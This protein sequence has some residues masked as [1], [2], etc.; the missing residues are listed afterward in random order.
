MSQI[1][2]SVNGE[3]THSNVTECDHSVKFRKTPVKSN[4]QGNGRRIG[5]DM[6]TKL[7][8]SSRLHK[9]NADNVHRQSPVMERS[10]H[11]PKILSLRERKC[12]SDD[13]TSKVIGTPSTSKRTGTRFR[14]TNYASSE[15]K[16]LRKE[17][18]QSFPSDSQEDLS[19]LP[20]DSESSFPP[21]QDSKA[22]TKSENDKETESVQSSD[23]KKRMFHRV[24]L[25]THS[26]TVPSIDENGEMKSKIDNHTT[27]TPKSSSKQNKFDPKLRRSKVVEITRVEI[28]ASSS[29]SGKEKL[30]VIDSGYGNGSSE[31][32]ETVEDGIG[33][34]KL[35]EK[36]EYEVKA[37]S[38]SPNERFLKFDIEIGRGSFKTVFKGLDTET[39][40]AVAWCE[41]QDYLNDKV[42]G[43]LVKD[44]KWNKSER[45]RFKEEAEMLKGLQHPNIVRF[46]DYW[47]ETNLRGR[48]VIILVTELMTSGTLKTYIK[49][50][51]K[52]NLKVLKNWCRQ[53]LKGLGFLH[54]RT[55]QV[56]HR[57]L[58]CDNIF[59]TGTTGSVKIGDLGLA[60]LKNK[61]FAKSVIG[62]P[63]FMAPEMYEEHYDEAVDVYA[64]GMCMLEMA[65]SEY[66]YKECT[67]A[68]QIYR[69]V[70]SG[71]R[72]EACDKVLDPEIRDIIEGCITPNRN[73]RY[74]VKQLLQHDFFLEDTGLK[75]ELVNKEDETNNSSIIQLRL[76]VVDPTKRKNKHKENEAIQF[77]FDMDKDVAEEVAQEM[78]KSAFLLEEDGRIASKQIKDRVVHIK[79]E[80]ERRLNESQNKITDGN[81]SDT[82]SSSSHSQLVPSSHSSQQPVAFNS[83][84]ALNINQYSKSSTPPFPNTSES[85]TNQQLQQ[86]QGNV[87]PTPNSV[88]NT[89]LQVQGGDYFTSNEF[90]AEAG[91]GQHQSMIHVPGTG[92]TLA[93]VNRQQRSSSISVIQHSQANTVTDNQGMK[94]I[95]VLTDHKEQITVIQTQV[96][97]SSE[98]SGVNTGQSVPNVLTTQASNLSHLDISAAQQHQNH[99]LQ[100]GGSHVTGGTTSLVSGTAP[101]TMPS[102]SSSQSVSCIQEEPANSRDSETDS[103]GGT[104]LDKSKRKSRNKRRKTA[105]KMP[106]LKVLSLD[107]EEIECELELSNR[108][109]LT[110]KFALEN[111]KPDEI[112][113]NLV[114]NDLLTKAQTPAIIGLLMEV[115]HMVEEN[116]ETAVNYCVT[117]N[118]TPSSSPCTIRRTRIQSD[119]DSA[120]KLNFD[121][122]ESTT[123][124]GSEKTDPNHHVTDTNKS[125]STVIIS[126]RKKFFVSRV[127][128]SLPVESKISEDDV[129]EAT[130]TTPE[131]QPYQSTPVVSGT[132]LPDSSLPTESDVSWKSTT[133]PP[134]VPIDL[135]D[136]KEKLSQISSSQK[137]AAGNQSTA[138]TPGD[139]PQTPYPEQ[140]QMVQDQQQPNLPSQV[141]YL[142][143]NLQIP[144]SQSPQH[145]QQPQIPQDVNQSLPQ[146][147]QTSWQPGHQKMNPPSTAQIS[148]YAGQQPMFGYQYPQGQGMYYPQFV[149]PEMMMTYQQQQFQYLQQLQQQQQQNPQFAMPPQF[150][151]PNYMFPQGQMPMYPQYMNQSQ[152]PHIQ[153]E[154]SGS[155]GGSPPR[156]P[157]QSRRI[158]R[159]EGSSDALNQA[160]SQYSSQDGKK[161]NMGNA[162]LAGLEQAII[163][164][165]HGHR[166][167]PSSGTTHSSPNFS[168]SMLPTTQISTET[169][170]EPT[171]VEKGDQT[172]KAEPSSTQTQT[173]QSVKKSRFTVE[174]VKENPEQQGSDEVDSS[175]DEVPGTGHAKE[176]SQ[177]GRFKVTTIKDDVSNRSIEESPVIENSQVVD[178]ETNTLVDKAS[179]PAQFTNKQK[180]QSSLEFTRAA[181]IS[182]LLERLYR[183][184]P[185]SSSTLGKKEGLTLQMHRAAS[186]DIDASIPARKTKRSVSL[187]CLPSFIYSSSDIGDG[188][189]DILP[190]HL[191]NRRGS[192][193]SPGD[194]LMPAD[195]VDSSTQTSP[196]VVKKSPQLRTPLIRQEK[197]E[198]ESP[199]SEEKKKIYK[200]EE[201]IE[202]K[203]LCLR[204]QKERNQF[205]CMQQKEMAEFLQKKGLSMAC[206]M[207]PITTGSTVSSASI[208][209]IL[210][211]GGIPISPVVMTTMPANQ[212]RKSI[213]KQGKTFSEDFFKYTDLSLPAKAPPKQDSKKSLNELKQEMEK[214]GW[215]SKSVVSSDSNTAVASGNNTIKQSDS[216]NM[217]NIDRNIPE[218]QVPSRK[219]SV[220]LTNMSQNFIPDQFRQQQLLQSMFQPMF[221]YNQYSSFP[222]SG[223]STPNPYY[224]YATPS[225]MNMPQQGM[226]QQGMP[227]GMPQQMPQ[228]QSIPQAMNQQQGIPKIMSQPGLS[229]GIPLGVPQGISASKIPVT[230]LQSNI[231]SQSINSGSGVVPHSNNI[232]NQGKE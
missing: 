140:Q 136:L 231:P 48:K 79:R 225:R 46:Y 38:T 85:G 156:S 210:G 22:R 202:Y 118:I 146:T 88:A 41:L 207:T 39:G 26:P 100:A 219:S 52:I 80:R 5:V 29:T 112:A 45:Q 208:S 81:Q 166:S 13:I 59:I 232:N 11:A 124:E 176:T 54:T 95:E 62:T 164:S 120:K 212:R 178:S 19:V 206:L 147:S 194:R 181:S 168:A 34:D 185:T 2:N 220:D 148:Q 129:E 182:R 60:T 35:D 63:E 76:R 134:N 195:S 40:V 152:P 221:P 109:I 53:I 122:A 154:A 167:M 121:E 87:A 66:P 165:L 160:H 78:V 16:E 74:C 114:D 139:F 143:G 163:M 73:E 92:Q 49:R 132:A 57:D 117:A 135:T 170:S 223:T 215:D 217:N 102:I 103:A 97:Q 138:V 56:I 199:S 89:S 9:R 44:K 137:L 187:A 86:G 192:M 177:K 28:D 98:A 184:V 125:D 110:F 175:P 23:I 150:M 106:R 64:F 119:T 128:D 105:E 25:V 43:L 191:R 12:L 17:R 141:S 7:S 83:Q 228:Q 71:V 198:E 1:E 24:G 82:Q 151:F 161:A 104:A 200:L 179:S 65:T 222:A 115:I 37:L 133:Y 226:V 130:A 190:S 20:K 171:E 229:Q 214:S 68:A 230:A 149:P 113:Q 4:I 61:S 108:T 27:A 96:S 197:I 55:P 213:D 69:K 111:D 67:N 155:N 196:A 84:T 169:L 201:D 216:L 142:A 18:S 70:T 101:T 91:G 189:H 144:G 21:G 50:F 218:R 31:T 205:Q 51:R 15:R 127:N 77:D 145:G 99:I 8:V 42:S 204:H 209:P 224:P 180:S 174:T 3:M 32:N 159:E 90:V 188:S 58:K 123:K 211:V 157:S 6:G 107:K 173:E 193:R 10:S 153:G 72:P 30:S 203:E 33:K 186:F 116:P 75:V 183:Q 14:I 93:P 227:Q 162:G 47:E 36:N 172:T 158:L 94:G 131:N 126:N